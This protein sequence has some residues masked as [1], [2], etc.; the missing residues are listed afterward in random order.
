MFIIDHVNLFNEIAK[1]EMSI[2]EVAEKAG[3]AESTLGNYLFRNVEKPDTVVIGKIA[4]V[5]NVEPKIFVKYVESN[6][7]IPHGEFMFM[8]TD[9]EQDI[10]K[11]RSDKATLEE[12]G[13]KYG[14]TRERV[15]Q[16]EAKALTK[17]RWYYKNQHYPSVKRMLEAKGWVSEQEEEVNKTQRNPLTFPIEELNLANRSYFCLKRAGIN[18][19]GDLCQKTEAELMRYRNLGRFCIEDIKSHL[20]YNGF[21]L[22]AF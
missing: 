16:L 1:S 4:K 22:K 15:R 14:V 12:I 6:N 20:A 21:E 18:T 19:V 8:L 9:R 17:L 13:E 10:L 3:I 5:L 11:M 7:D 2:K